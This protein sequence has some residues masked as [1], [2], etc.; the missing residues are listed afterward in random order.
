M[1]S[2]KF[3]AVGDI[4][5]C[6]SVGDFIEKYGPQFPFETIKDQFAGSDI[7]FGNLE[8]SISER[9]FPSKYWPAHMNFRAHP[10]V[11]RGLKEAGFNVLS[12][13][14]N[15]VSNYGEDALLDTI[16]LLQSNGISHV[17]AGA[18]AHEAY[19][20]LILN[21]N[22]LRIA[23][24]AYSTILNGS[25]IAKNEKSGIAQFSLKK[26]LRSIKAAREKA[27]LVVVSMH[28]GIDYETNPVPQHME[29]ARQ[30]IDA[31]AVLIIGHH[32]HVIQ[33]IERYMNGLIIY[34]LGNFVFDDSLEGTD[35][36]LMFNF[37]LSDEGIEKYEIIPLEKN[38]YHQPCVVEGRKRKKILL[39]KT[40]IEN[41]E[42]MNTVAFAREM[43]GKFVLLNLKLSLKERS[44][45]H[46]KNF[47]IKTF[48][49]ALPYIIWRLLERMVLQYIG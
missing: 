30:M 23:I 33:P 4:M 8:C 20:P 24:L 11:V 14:N 47:D 6:R 40:E 36:S 28:W 15:H 17:G 29:C 22:N 21:Q 43:N 45:Y 32:P 27:D 42:S 41:S 19:A 3:T 13:A 10:K 25:R 1:K 48:F 49:S 7:I 39:D 18:S 2:I 31:G 26:A 46:L 12:L 16:R 34:S 44:L 38:E 5:L 37:T 35:I 9:G